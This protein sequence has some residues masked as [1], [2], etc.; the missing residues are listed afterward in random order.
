MPLIYRVMR[1]DGNQPMIGETATSLGVRVPRDISVDDAGNVHSDSAGMSVAPSLRDLPF[2]LVPRRLS[3]LRRGA[4]GNN[5]HNVWRHG[6]G[7]FID[8]AVAEKLVLRVTS[9]VHGVVAPSETI[10]F[11]EY[12]NALHET[13]EGWLIDEI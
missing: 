2:Y 12:V 13:R 1:P 5:N 10:A 9:D 11:S 4:K 8:G 3:N 7:A 6:T